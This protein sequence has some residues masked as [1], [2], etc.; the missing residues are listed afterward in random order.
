VFVYTF[1]YTQSPVY[2]V[3]FLQWGA[4]KRGKIWHCIILTSLEV[5]ILTKFGS[6]WTFE[7]GRKMAQKFMY[8]TKNDKKGTKKSV[9][10]E[11]WVKNYGNWF[12]NFC[13]YCNWR[14]IHELNGTIQARLI[15]DPSFDYH[16]FFFSI[17]FY[18]W[19]LSVCQL[20]TLVVGH[21]NFNF[22]LFFSTQ[23]TQYFWDRIYGT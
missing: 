16:F 6:N 9:R 14:K 22:C 23:Y 21:F 11:K 12:I 2:V 13:S 5:H 15:H 20:T 18:F 3:L 4:Y 7:S 19:L 17:F 8:Q 1:C 10:W